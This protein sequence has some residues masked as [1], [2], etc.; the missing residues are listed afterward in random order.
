MTRGNVC[1]RFVWQAWRLATSAFVLRDRHSTH[2]SGLGVVTALVAAGPLWRRVSFAWQEWGLATSAFVLWQGWRLATSAVVLC[3]RRGAH[4][5]GLGLAAALVVALGDVCL[6]FVRQGLA[7]VAAL[8]VAL[9]DVCLRFVRQAWHLAISAFVL[10]G[11]RATHSTGLALVAALVAAG[12]LWRR[13]SFARGAHGT[14]LALVAALV[15]A[16]PLCLWRRASF[17]WQAWRFLPSFCVAGVALGDVCLRFVAGV[18]LGN[19]CFPFKFLCGRRGAHGTGLGLAAALVVALGD[20]CLRFVRQA[21]RSRHW[22]GFGRGW[23]PV[24]VAPRFFCVAGVALS[25]FVLYGRRGA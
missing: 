2:G 9:G 6:R 7:L 19:I 21:R 15:A 14:G 17:A 25:A 18:A 20:V 5:T 16:G 10:C 13:A 23:S 3:G 4:G 1:L 8:F 24:P 11:R 12:P 22:A